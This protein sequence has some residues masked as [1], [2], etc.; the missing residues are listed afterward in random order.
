MPTNVNSLD[1]APR[2]PGV[3]LD[4]IWKEISEPAFDTA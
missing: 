2:P 3:W 4:G 1:L